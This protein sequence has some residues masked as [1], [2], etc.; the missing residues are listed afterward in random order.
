MWCQVECE[1]EESDPYTCDYR[2]WTLKNQDRILL[3]YITLIIILK[4]K[5]TTLLKK[6]SNSTLGTHFWKTLFWVFLFISLVWQHTTLLIHFEYRV[7]LSNNCAYIKQ[8]ICYKS[9]MKQ[10]SN[11]YKMVFHIW[12]TSSTLN[13]QNH[14]ECVYNNFGNFHRNRMNG[15]CSYRESATMG[16][17]DSTIFKFFKFP[18]PPRECLQKLVHVS[19]DGHIDENLIHK[20]FNINF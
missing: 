1:G 7:W 3:I 18:K 15:T 12:H 17:P 8:I 10:R 20:I 2:K 11:K 13:F 9:N 16:T 4:T 14:R 6:N 5:L 19:S